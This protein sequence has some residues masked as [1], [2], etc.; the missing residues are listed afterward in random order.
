MLFDYLERSG[1]TELEIS[2]DYYWFIGKEEAYDPL[3]DSAELMIGQLSEDWGRLKAILED[4]NPPI[5]YS[6]VWLSSILRI[7][8]EKSVY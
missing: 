3:E 7:V 6:L 2:E 5:G 8:G 4:E 1:R